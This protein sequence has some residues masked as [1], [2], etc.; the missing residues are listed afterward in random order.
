MPE[1]LLA[2]VE[3]ELLGDGRCAAHLGLGLCP[4]DPLLPVAPCLAYPRHASVPFLGQPHV[5]LDPALRIADQLERVVVNCPEVMGH[6][7]AAGGA[8]LEAVVDVVSMQASERLVETDVVNRPRR[9]HQQEAVDY[10][11][12]ARAGVRGRVCDLP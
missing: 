4:P 1:L 2:R 12:L 6:H 10:V 3:L 11:D 8:D 7:L 9:E 5:G